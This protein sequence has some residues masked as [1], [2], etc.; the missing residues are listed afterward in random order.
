M[1][2]R[3]RKGTRAGAERRG[4]NRVA[5][6]AS[7]MLRRA[8][9]PIS[10]GRARPSS[11][12]APLPLRSPPRCPPRA[13]RALPRRGG[14]APR[15]GGA[16]VER[17]P[18]LVDGTAEIFGAE[19]P[20]GAPYSR[21]K[22]AVFTWHGATLEMVGEPEICYS[23]KET[24]M[25]AYSNVEGI[26][27]ARRKEA[28]ESSGR[29]SALGSRSSARPTSAILPREDPPQ[30]RR[31]QGLGPHCDLDL[32][33]GGIRAPRRSARRPWTAP[34]TSPR[35]SRSRC[36]WFSS[37][38]NPETTRAVQVLSRGEWAD[39]RRRWTPTRRA[40][41]RAWSSTPR[42]GSTAW[43]TSCSYTRWTR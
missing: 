1:I 39:A 14:G 37:T 20:K 30:L 29:V 33:Q 2:T 11:P 15:R 18:A 36:P 42:A 5:A 4:G 17:R 7:Q 26:M 24:P 27:E 31:P 35:A 38:A 41:T 22:H 8:P 6:D 34:W 10:I 12:R 3:L 40:T 16:R 13:R 21:R 32:G 23:A 19:L 28:A 9:V 25:V 43:G